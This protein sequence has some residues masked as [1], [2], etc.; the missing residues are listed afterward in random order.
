MKQSRQTVSLR[1]HVLAFG[2]VMFFALF[3]G[4]VM[5]SAFAGQE[6]QTPT[7]SEHPLLAMP[8][9]QGP[10]IIAGPPPQELPGRPAAQPA[11]TQTASQPIATPA[12]ELPPA[13]KRAAGD[14]KTEENEKPYIIG[15]LDVLY[16]RVWN[17]QNLTGPVDVRPDGM[18][19]LPLV[20]EMKA[21][22]VTVAA[23]KEVIRTKL[24]DFLNSPEVDVQ[25]SRVNS[26]K[27]L[28]LGAVNRTGAFPLVGRTTV[29]EALSS[30]GGFRDFA[31][32]KKI[33]ILRG[34]RR[35]SFNYKEV[36]LGKHPEQDIVLEN[37]DKIVVPE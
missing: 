12:V 1:L 36:I 9:A 34:T 30:A 23:L 13:N 5:S 20:G 3:S 19:S 21:D 7:D 37:G 14:A 32:Q 6:P 35:F 27:V 10:A 4:G 11:A 16:I 24:G 25:V 2:A 31:N 28:V 8:K 15:S 22:G 29:L 26:K 18:I 17:N 33:Y